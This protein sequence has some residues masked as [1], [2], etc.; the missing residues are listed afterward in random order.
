ML[1]PRSVARFGCK[2]TAVFTYKNGPNL[3]RMKW[4]RPIRI[5]SNVLGCRLGQWPK[6]VWRNSEWSRT[7]PCTTA[8]RTGR[9][10]EAECVRPY[11]CRSA[12]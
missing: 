12:F 8:M 9:M 2:S 4:K 6:N 11:S 3:V 7:M 10:A 5:V 1:R